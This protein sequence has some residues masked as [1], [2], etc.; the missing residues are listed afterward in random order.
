VFR[1]E[2]TMGL[3]VV[4]DWLDRKLARG[5]RLSGDGW[6]AAG[7]LLAPA[8][9]IITVFGLYPIVAALWLSLHD[10][11][12]GQGVFSGLSNYR[13]ALTSGAFWN[14]VV[15]TTYYLVGTIPPTL[16]LGFLIA[17]WLTEITRARALFRTIYFLPYI[18]SAFAAAVVWRALLNPQ[19]GL[20][21]V[22]LES[23]GLAT[24][25]WY[26]EPRGLLHILTDGWIP[27]DWGPSLALCCV[28]AFDIWHGLGFTI[29]IL[30]AGLASIPRELE[31]SARLDGAG[32]RQVLWHV[33]VPLLS[34]SLYFLVIVGTIKGFQAFNSFYAISQGGGNTLGT[35]ENLVLY[36]FANFY[37]FGRWGYGAAI[38]TL[39][40]VIIIGLT[41]IQGYWARRW[42]HYA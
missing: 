13:E 28:I 20:A 36:L 22:L 6:W 4:L 27:L 11:Y 19:G 39:L 2:A 12:Y 31:E 25:H 10:G 9:I 26:M 5:S 42:V 16:V 35:T 23:L 21:N 24:Q 29:V 32:T 17:R 37:E 8:V 30:L 18:T 41:L 34:P 40:L 7:P 3:D 38:A 15:V 14:S 1:K 33:T